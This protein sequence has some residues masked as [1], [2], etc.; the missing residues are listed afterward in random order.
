[1]SDDL[2]TISAG[3]ISATVKAVGAE[4]C[5][6]TAANGLELLWQA[7]EVWPRHAPWLFPIVGRLKDDQLHHR[8]RT[9]PMTQHG[10]ARDLR[11]TWLERSAEACVLELTD[12]DTTRARYPFAFRLGLTY[13]IT[14]NALETAV[15][16]AN[17][18]AEV[19]PASF[20]AHPA[21][22]WPL[23]PGQPKESYR[24]IFAEPELAPIRRLS[25]GL[26]RARPEPSPIA[27]PVLQLNERLFDNDAVILD[28]PASR[29]VRLV[30]TKGPALELAWDNFRQLGIWSKPGGAP[31][32]CIEPWRGFASPL[33]FD[34]EFAAKP[35]IMHIAPGA[36]ETLRCRIGIE[37]SN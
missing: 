10:F 21:F 4:L 20:G 18:G 15:E 6:L 31:F 23:L 16:I 17:P 2:H 34:A 33:D 11:F 14:A 32:L 1:M 13:R 7:G 26:L 36:A 5:S 24:L 12:D 22:N 37:S 19:L 35:G 30:G 25:G 8:G 9:Y 29:S 27:G 3:G 28:Q